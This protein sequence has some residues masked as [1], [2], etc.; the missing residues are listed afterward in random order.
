[1]PHPVD[2][3]YLEKTKSPG[4]PASKDP[5]VLAWVILTQYWFMIDA[6]TD[7]H[8]S[9]IAV[10]ALCIASFADT[11]QKLP[12]ATKIDKWLWFWGSA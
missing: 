9:T 4:V 5:V 7:I 12:I 3:R 8:I 10:T 6:Q 2:E 1:M 11:L